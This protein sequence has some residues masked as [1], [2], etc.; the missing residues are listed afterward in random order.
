MATTIHP[1]P[2][3]NTLDVSFGKAVLGGYLLGFLALGGFFFAVLSVATDTIP[4]VARIGVAAGIAFWIGIMG[5]VVLVGR[6]S[7]RNEEALHG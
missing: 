2:E 4:L 7:M 6:W 5:G 3:D 1:T